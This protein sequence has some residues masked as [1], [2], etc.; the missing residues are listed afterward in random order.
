MLVA[1]VLASFF[2]AAE[3]HGVATAQEKLWSTSSF[4]S[5]AAPSRLEALDLSEH[6]DRCRRSRGSLFAALCL[7]E[8]VGMFM[9]SRA[10]TTMALVALSGGIL[11]LLL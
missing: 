6:L 3:L 2:Q 11:T 5:I 1:P 10:I 7:A 4:D 8:R 9:A